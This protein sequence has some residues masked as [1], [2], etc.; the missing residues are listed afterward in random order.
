[1]ISGNPPEASA[2]NKVGVP[3][4]FSRNLVK[5]NETLLCM[6]IQDHLLNF[7]L[8][9]T[10]HYISTYGLGIHLISLA[11]EDWMGGVAKLRLYLLS[12]PFVNFVA[13]RSFVNDLT[14]SS[15]F[16][17]QHLSFVNLNLER[18]RGGEIIEM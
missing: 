14:G 7:S 5:R 6:T 13:S 17:S 11:L 8:F 16:A 1:M 9:N 2:A 18:R 3:S 4:T 12:T 10:S 15:I